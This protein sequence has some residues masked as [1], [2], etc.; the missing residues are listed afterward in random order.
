MTVTET[1]V[2]RNLTALSWAS[3]QQRD[4]IWQGWQTRYSFLHT[5]T[6]QS[7]LPILL[8]HGFGAS[9]GHWRKNMPAL[10]ANHAVYALDLVG[11]GASEKPSTQY[12]I[13][14]WVEQVFEFWQTFIRQPVVLVGNS[15][16]S[17]VALIA[18]SVHPEM[19][20]G[21]VTISLP[22]LSARE[23]MIPSF[24]RPMVRSLESIFSHSLILKPIF[25][26][27]RHPR[28]IKPWAGMAYGDA[29][30]VDD[31][32]VEILS[33]PA[34]EKRAAAA[35]CRILQG[36]M[37]VNF[38]PRVSQAIS[39]LQIP[40]LMLWGT[41]DRMIPPVLGRKLATYS[42]LARLVELEG[43]GHC[44]HDEAPLQVNAEI[45]KWIEK[46]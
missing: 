33:R 13:S 34:Q 16:G 17:L 31:E 18:A 27:V 10:A 35:F 26:Y 3:V 36:M 38:S 46:L 20:K 2:T 7:D 11:F 15:I 32:L 6:A 4:W 1:L 42:P 12:N 21:I 41:Q 14:L 39:Q 5:D 43:L 8:L 29:S 37:N 28:V 9:I 30:I 40:L 25:Y 44:A 24:I 19:A 22:D 45:L 23:E